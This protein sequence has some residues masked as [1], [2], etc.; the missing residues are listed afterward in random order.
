MN[1]QVQGQLQ[2][3]ARLRKLAFG[4]QRA[5][6]L[7]EDTGVQS[8]LTAITEVLGLVMMLMGIRAMNFYQ[9]ILKRPPQIEETLY[10]VATTSAYF[11][12][13]SKC[14]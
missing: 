5:H 13:M 4:P 11:S 12:S 8:E 6:N 9:G 7:V 1:Y 10:T 3:I 2:V 14:R